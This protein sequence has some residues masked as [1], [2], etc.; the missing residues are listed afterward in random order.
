MKAILLAAGRGSRMG[1][2]TRDL[3]KC[4]APLAGKT[5]L[6][7]QTEALL[8]A[9]FDDIVVARG[10]KSET[11]QGRFATLENPRWAETNMVRTLQCAAEHLRS[12]PCLVSYT[13]IVYHP[14]HLRALARCREDL[15]IAYDARW[16][17]LW[18]ARFED[19]LSD[20]ETFLQKDG[21]LETIGGKTSD[22]NDIQG[23]YMGLLL[24]R[25]AG[26]NLAERKLDALGSSADKLDMTS[27]LRHLLAEGAKIG[28]VEVSGKWCEADNQDDLALYERKL[29]GS[30]QGT[31]SHDWRWDT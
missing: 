14:D 7:W 8:Q 11:V 4:L 2:R 26:W 22:E 28:T 18:S 10:Y 20:A 6:Q 13:D 21:I 30:P 29:T 27:L 5:L 23:Q 1:E 17:E 31:W 12:G 15:A 19:P 25:P 3:P 24:F 9:G 16:K